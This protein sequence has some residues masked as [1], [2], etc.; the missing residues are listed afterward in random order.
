M[1]VPNQGGLDVDALLP[2]FVPQ[3]RKQPILERRAGLAADKLAGVQLRPLN[4]GD[5]AGIGQDPRVEDVLLI[6]VL[7]SHLGDAIG[8]D[9]PFDGALNPNGEAVEGWK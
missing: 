8:T 7:D 9:G 2:A 5:A 1:D 6:A 4:A 3:L